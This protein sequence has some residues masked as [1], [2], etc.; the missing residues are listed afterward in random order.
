MSIHKEIAQKLMEAEATHVPMAQITSEYDGLT[1]DDAYKIQ[2]INID[3]K[4]ESGLI[5]TGKKIGLTSK[6]MQNNLGVD[7]PDFG[8][9]LNDMEVQNNRIEMKDIL[10]PRCEGE[11][12]F[13]LKEDIEGPNATVEDVMNATDYICGAIEV[14]G[15]RIKDWKLTI[16]DTV[17]DNASSGMYVLGET[18]FKPGEV[19]L[20]EVFMKLYKNGEE[21][22]SGYGK[23]VLGDPAFAVAWLANCLHR[24]GVTLKKGEVVLSGALS[25][26]L[27]AEAGDEFTCEF[28]DFG[29]VSV[30]FE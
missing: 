16:V 11:L 5:M 13:V 23:D 14:V 9:L 7:Q 3:S 24:Y 17:A 28:T 27:A 29:T 21:I 20:K 4:L 1:I 15:S 19:D 12:A 26:A 18:K 10:Q 2:L 6:A 25:V 30:S 22:N 8:H